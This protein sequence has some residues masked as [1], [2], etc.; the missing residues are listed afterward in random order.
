MPPSYA[1][2][3]NGFGFGLVRPGWWITTRERFPRDITRMEAEILIYQGKS[4]RP[5]ATDSMRVRAAGWGFRKISPF[6]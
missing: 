4:R 6:K 2:A 5:A 3:G 1:A